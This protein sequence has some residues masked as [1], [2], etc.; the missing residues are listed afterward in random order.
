MV[1]VF[2]PTKQVGCS[3]KFTGF[4]RG[5]FKVSEKISGVL[6]KV[7]CVRSGTWSIIHGDRMRKARKQVL[8]GDVIEDDE[9]ISLEDEL[10][11]EDERVGKKSLRN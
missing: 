1:Y 10:L 7:N 4:W 8:A 11:L 9:A 6:Y 2:F 3:A 5:P